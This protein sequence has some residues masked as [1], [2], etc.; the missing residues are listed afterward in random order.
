MRVSQA[1]GN[2]EEELHVEGVLG[3]A[4]AASVDGGDQ[5]AVQLVHVVLG[6]RPTARTCLVLHLQSVRACAYTH[7]HTR[8]QNA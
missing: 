8:T 5:S 1:V 3:D 2:V 6:H 4:G 7:T